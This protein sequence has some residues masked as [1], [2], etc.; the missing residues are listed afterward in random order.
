[1]SN[2]SGSAGLP[3]WFATPLGQHLLEVELRYFDRELADVFGF[4]AFQLGLPEHDFLRANRM[5]LRCATGTDGPVALHAEPGALPIQTA[6]ADLVVLPHALE[7]S[8]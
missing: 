7:F 4:N 1:M 2:P 6:A 8:R 5:P 3:E